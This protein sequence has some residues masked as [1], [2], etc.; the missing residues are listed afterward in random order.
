MKQEHLR[1]YIIKQAT[2]LVNI[3]ASLDGDNIFL[4]SK[5]VEYL[6]Y[7]K[8]ILNISTEGASTN[9]MKSVG[10]DFSYTSS[11]K[12]ENYNKEFISKL[13]PKQNLISNYRSDIVAKKLIEAVDL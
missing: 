8:P 13:I 1:E 5:I 4:S 10:V 3:D 6:Y 9:F 2:C 11:V 7:N 12:K